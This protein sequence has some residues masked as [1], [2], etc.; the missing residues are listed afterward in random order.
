MAFC[1]LLYWAFRP[2]VALRGVRVAT[3]GNEHFL[4]LV[5]LVIRR[6]VLV[7]GLVC[8]VGGANCRTAQ[9]RGSEKA[10]AAIQQIDDGLSDLDLLEEA[11]TKSSATHEEK[12]AIKKRFYS[13][14]KKFTDAKPAIKAVGQ[15]ADQAQAEAAR[16]EVDASRMRRIYLACAIAAGI[17]IVGI[18]LKFKSAIVGFFKRLFGI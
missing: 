13:V 18:I 1:N 7:L 14:R 2:F 10:S 17:L 16:N 4:L 6:A 5:D 8:L 3:V 15:L 11:F 12:A 9:G